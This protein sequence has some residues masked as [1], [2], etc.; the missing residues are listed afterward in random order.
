MENKPASRRAALKTGLGLLA[1]AG[2]LGAA[3]STAQ[4]QSAKA[5]PTSVGYQAKPSNGQ[6]CSGCVQYIKP[7]AC[8]IVSGTISPD[9]WC[10]LYSPAG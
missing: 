1:A 10:E 5:D 9:G 4:A 7:N 2:T 6:K 8:K 3:A